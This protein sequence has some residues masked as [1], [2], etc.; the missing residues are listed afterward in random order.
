MWM[1]CSNLVSR[2]AHPT[3]PTSGVYHRAISS[4][5]QVLRQALFVVTG[6]LCGCMHVLPQD[7]AVTAVPFEVL[8]DG[9]I[10]V[11]VHLDDHGPFSFVLDTGAT[12]SL[13]V[14][15]LGNGLELPRLGSVRIQG[16]I[17]SDEVPL[18]NV[19][20]IRLGTETW[21]NA[22]VANV[23]GVSD[24]TARIDGLLG[25]DFLRRYGVEV[26]TSEGL[27]R[28]YRPETIARRAYRGW[29][30]IPLE[31]RNIGRSSQPLYFLEIEINGRRIPGLFDIG[32]GQN[33][34]NS[35]AARY[36]HVVPVSLDGFEILS[37]PL[38]GAAIFASFESAV[39]AEAVRWRNA[40]F[41]ITDTRI[42]ET[43]LHDASP[44]A[45]VGSRLFA[46]RDFVIDFTRNRL[47]VKV[48]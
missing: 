38:T 47:L 5:P 32:A 41:S 19:G 39:A 35:P 34:I 42:F 21:E 30:S 18:L 27:L 14:G 4:V 48:E 1:L 10:A 12:V 8:G 2:I 33:I 37:G 26:E 7:D 24:A 22:R 36:L 16:V 25:L 46:E 29:T 15:A 43:L 6:G 9:R 3:L 45:I 28:L 20:H 40:T 44:L 23:S 11:A 17:A 13:V 31:P